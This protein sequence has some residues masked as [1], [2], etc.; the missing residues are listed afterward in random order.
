M[1]LTAS[2]APPRTVEASSPGRPASMNTLRWWSG[3]ECTASRRPSNAAPIASIAAT[4]RPSETFGTASNVVGAIEGSVEHVAPG[5]Q[6]RPAV[7]L[8]RGVEHHRVQVDRDG[9]LA[10]DR[11]AGTERDVHRAEDLLVLEDV[12]GKGRAVVGAHPELRQVPSG[13]AVGLEA[14]EVLGGEAAL[15]SDDESVPDHHHRRL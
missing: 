3:S 5:V 9:Y 14:P 7:N 15:A 10:A 6:H 2:S 4:S 11:R 12:P 8:E 1:R 13:V